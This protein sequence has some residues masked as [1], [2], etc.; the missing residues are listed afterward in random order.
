MNAANPQEMIIEPIR[1][2]P[3]RYLL[4]PD[5]TG[6]DSILEAAS[7]I[8]MIVF[9]NQVLSVNRTST[10]W[11]F[12]TMILK[13]LQ[14]SFDTTNLP[15]NGRFWRPPILLGTVRQSSM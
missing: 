12:N 3:G 15:N 8:K 14:A 11:L 4:P 13:I 6:L 2:E 10:V 1:G 5:P 7:T 9:L